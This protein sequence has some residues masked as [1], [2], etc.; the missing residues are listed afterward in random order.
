MTVM[1]PLKVETHRSTYSL[2]I[3]ILFSQKVHHLS[4]SLRFLYK[5][6]DLYSVDDNG[7]DGV[8]DD[9]GF[10]GLPHCPLTWDNGS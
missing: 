6:S 7:V 9:D 2:E 8:N 4:T 10:G 3:E 1:R 5:I